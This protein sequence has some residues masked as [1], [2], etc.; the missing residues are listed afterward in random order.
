MPYFRTKPAKVT[1]YLALYD[2]AAN[3]YHVKDA[4]D[5]DSPIQV[6][7]ADKFLEAVEEIKSIEKGPI[8]RGPR[9]SSDAGLTLAGTPRKKPG[10]K[11]KLEPTNNTTEREAAANGSSGSDSYS[12]ECE[13]VLHR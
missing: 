10:R 12:E 7:P 13:S 3:V 11:P 4:D 8:K 1:Q 6:V 2:P 9:K 5:D